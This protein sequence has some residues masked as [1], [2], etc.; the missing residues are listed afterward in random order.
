MIRVLFKKGD[1]VTWKLD[2][3]T[4]YICLEDE[5]NNRVSIRENSRKFQEGKLVMID[6]LNFKINRWNPFK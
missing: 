3:N 5:A 2:P 4:V 6:D 1:K